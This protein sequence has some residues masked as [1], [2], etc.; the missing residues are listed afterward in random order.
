MIIQG[1]SA[2]SGGGGGGTITGSG[3]INKVAK[4]T[5]ASAIGNS[6]ITDDGSKINISYLAGAG[7]T[8][9]VNAAGDLSVGASAAGTFIALTDVLPPTLSSYAGTAGFGWI[10][11]NGQTGLI[12]FNLFNAS[13]VIPVDMVVATN[14]TLSG[15]QNFD[16]QTAIAGSR[17]LVWQQSNQTQNGVY[18]Q[19]AGAWS[20]TTDA[21]STGELNNLTV[22][23]NYT[24]TGTTYGGS[25][26][27]QITETPTV[28]VS[29]IVFQEGGIGAGGGT[30]GSRVRLN[31][32]NPAN[33][34]N[35]IDSLNFA[36]EW[37]WSTLSTQTG[38]LWTA[39]A[40]S[41]GILFSLTSSSTAAASNTQTLFNIA[42]SGT[43]GT[44][45]QTTYGAKISNTHAGTLSTN[46]ALQL[47]ASGGTTD[48]YALV[49]T[50]GKVGIN[51]TVP[52][53]LFHVKGVSTSTGQLVLVTNSTPAS[54][55]SILDDG[56]FFLGKGCSLN[57]SGST[58]IVIGNLSVLSGSSVVSSIA[59]G[60]QASVSNFVSYGTAIGYGGHAGGP[61]SIAIGGYLASAT[62]QCAIAIGTLSSATSFGAIMLSTNYVA[63][64]TNDIIGSFKVHGSLNSVDSS[65][66]QNLF[67]SIA[68][69]QV[70]NFANDIRNSGLNTQ[71]Y[72]DSASQNVLVINN[73]TVAP[74][75]TVTSAANGTGGNAF[76]VIFTSNSVSFNTGDRVVFS[77]FG[78]YTNT[79]YYVRPITATTFAIFT[80]RLL[81]LGGALGTGVAYISTD[82]GTVTGKS[83]DPITPVVD[84]VQ[85]F[86][87]D[88]AGA[89]TASPK[90]L[91]ET[92]D[93]IT[94]YKTGTFTLSN[95]TPDFAYDP[96]TALPLETNQV[97]A[98]LIQ[99][100]QATGILG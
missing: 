37:D 48:S 77:G 22:I 69:I 59:I 67:V 13:T 19:A 94:L 39:N 42:L 30:G 17:T 12:P 97:L 88:A 86:T 51:T 27:N 84:S 43:N 65:L 61:G 89:G 32:I 25:Y 98:T 74:T 72:M 56:T 26:F 85:Y 49:T 52:T 58:N 24:K 6:A 11:N 70:L 33:N 60:D 2:G 66:G 9:L 31:K 87:C 46:V 10:V 14:V 82:T 3:T 93:F 38:F 64:Q 53:G 54:I 44:T 73:P 75:A 15:L 5:G 8:V 80:T 92:G 50:A 62:V 96:T 35:T 18:A 68:G 63:T 91:L 55:F 95:V 1:G 90:W 100:I 76:G 28:G 36:Q 21:D 71:T 29:N 99:T 78:V 16:G 83:R 40:L 41:S 81:A 20:R 4:F 45:T 34:T 7:G 23:A 57:G 47:T 79:T